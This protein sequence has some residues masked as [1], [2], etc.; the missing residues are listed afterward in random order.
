MWYAEKREVVD[1]EVELTTVAIRRKSQRSALRLF[2]AFVEAELNVHLGDVRNLQIERGMV[3]FVK[4]DC[5][6][7]WNLLQIAG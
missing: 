4:G 5:R 1:S 2:E 6:V 7:C 3:S